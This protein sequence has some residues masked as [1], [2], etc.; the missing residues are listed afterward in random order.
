MTPDQIRNWMDRYQLF[1]SLHRGSGFHLTFGMSQFMTL[2]VVAAM[3]DI[4]MSAREACDVARSEIFHRNFLNKPNDSVSFT[5]NK[6]G[7]WIYIDLP[8]SVVTITVHLDPLYRGIRDRMGIEADSNPALAA[9]LA[10]WDAE[11]A[12]LRARQEG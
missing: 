5:R 9:E 4:G 10:L 12:K 8:G 1:S 6:E 7:R 11:L 3:M 2:S